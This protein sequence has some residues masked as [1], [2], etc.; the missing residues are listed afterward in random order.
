MIMQI[1]VWNTTMQIT[2]LQGKEPKTKR[3]TDENGQHVQVT[4]DGSKP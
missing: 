1:K 4:D 3:V 2:V